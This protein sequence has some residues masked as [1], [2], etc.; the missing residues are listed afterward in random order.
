MQWYR[1][2]LAHEFTLLEKENTIVLSYLKRDAVRLETKIQSQ[3]EKWGRVYTIYEV[4][5]VNTLSTPISPRITTGVNGDPVWVETVYP[6]DETGEAVSY[7]L[8][9][10]GN[11][12]LENQ[13]LKAR[14]EKKYYI[15]VVTFSN[16]VD[17]EI[18]IQ[19]MLEELETLLHYPE[20]NIRLEANQQYV[21]I[22]QLKEEKNALVAQQKIIDFQTKISELE[23][24]ALVDSEKW[25]QWEKE[26]KET[27]EKTTVESNTEW[28]KQGNDALRERDEK[29][30]YDAWTK[31]NM[32]KEKE[33]NEGKLSVDYAGEL[34]QM[35]QQWNELETKTDEYEKNLGISCE[36]LSQ[37]DVI[38]PLGENEWN[39]Y[40]KTIRANQ[41]TIEKWITKMEKTSEEKK[42]EVW[43]SIQPEWKKIKQEQPKIKQDV[44]EA[45]ALLERMAEERVGTLT[46]ET[47]N[48]FQ[49]EITS[50]V[51]KAQESLEK[52]EYGKSIF[53][54]QSML[55][56]VNENKG[57][58]WAVIPPMA[59]PFLGIIGM[60]G[61][62]M[63]YRRWKKPPVSVLPQWS[64]QREEKLRRE[65]ELNLIAA[66]ENAGTRQRNTGHNTS[67][68]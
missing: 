47:K 19:R 3:Y 44:E 66:H 67:C 45:I 21:E 8:D 7:T 18:R 13:F 37:V 34:K 4:S 59:W 46:R 14:E 6:T 28:I 60:G 23:S 12:T 58:G 10:G 68:Q 11:I 62:W 20:K 39:N 32:Q 49:S 65:N 2:T 29:K 40:Q 15:T 48:S 41:K 52:K 5:I 33:N 64:C 42:E 17:N 22:L 38:C 27:V 55:N 25:A 31:I 30:L 24:K 43:N 26:W 57:T 1:G 61:G 56:Y 54:A 63:M 50:A 51:Q 53:I 16:A 35:I 9:A 36:K